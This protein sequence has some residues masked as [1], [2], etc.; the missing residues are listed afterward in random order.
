M[1]CSY[2]G[3]R[4]CLCFSLFISSIAL[5]TILCTWQMFHQ[6][7]CNSFCLFFSLPKKVLPTKVKQCWNDGIS[8]IKYFDN[9]Y[10]FRQWLTNLLLMSIN[11]FEAP[12]HQPFKINN[13]SFLERKRKKKAWLKRVNWFLSKFMISLPGHHITELLNIFNRK[14][15]LAINKSNFLKQKIDYSKKII[16]FCF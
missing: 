16:C 1:N 14:R 13:L 15:I 6:G 2:V 4:N 10:P 8:L 7:M 11:R 5:S 12:D 3:G 9:F